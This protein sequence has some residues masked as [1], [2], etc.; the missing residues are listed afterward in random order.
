MADIGLNKRDL[1]VNVSA[2][3]HNFGEVLHKLRSLKAYLCGK[4][5]GLVKIQVN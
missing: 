4:C 1:H 3:S 2:N 5:I